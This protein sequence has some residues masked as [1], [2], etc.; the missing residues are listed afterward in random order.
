[1]RSDGDWEKHLT[2]DEARELEQSL[3]AERH[4][5]ANRNNDGP[6]YC[7]GK[8]TGPPDANTGGDSASAWCPAPSRASSEWLQ[9][10][11]ASAVEIGEINI[12]E[13]YATGAL[14]KVVAMMP[15]G[16]EKVL[17]QGT[18]P[19]EEPPVERVVKVPR[20][21]RGDNIRV[22]L[23]TTRTGTWQEIDAVELVGT[24]GSRQWATEAAASSQWGASDHGDVFGWASG[25]DTGLEIIKR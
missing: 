23:D 6:S 24:D 10:K 2:A 13:G 15:D 11:Y 21:I 18:E 12:H 4:R 20:G 14:S 7:A 9:L 1:L 8:A 25:R 22:Y 17:W 16:S 3:R 5:V 19:V